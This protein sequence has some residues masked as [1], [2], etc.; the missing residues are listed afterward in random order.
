MIR[1]LTLV[2]I[3]VAIVGELALHFPIVAHDTAGVGVDVALVEMY[4]E[5][6]GMFPPDGAVDGLELQHAALP[7]SDGSRVLYTFDGRDRRVRMPDGAVPATP[8]AVREAIDDG[9][10]ALRCGAE[11]IYKQ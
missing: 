9:H 11:V 1:L 8:G 4:A 5:D 2:V 6:T 7:C 10:F 3:V